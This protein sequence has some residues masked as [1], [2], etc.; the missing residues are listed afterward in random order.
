MITKKLKINLLNKIF[1]R[2]PTFQSL[3]G[4]YS[5]IGVD[6]NGPCEKDNASSSSFAWQKGL[7]SYLHFFKVNYYN[8][9]DIFFFKENEFISVRLKT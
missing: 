6:L 2:I 7:E 4:K 3:S 8:I 1:C 9:K 5:C